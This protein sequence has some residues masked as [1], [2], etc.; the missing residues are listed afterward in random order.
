[1]GKLSSMAGG[2]SC[3]MVRQVTNLSQNVPVELGP[4]GLLPWGQSPGPQNSSCRWACQYTCHPK[5]GHQKTH[6]AIMEELT[7][8]KDSSSSLSGTP[9]TICRLCSPFR[10]LTIFTN[11]CIGY[12]DLCSGTEQ[13]HHHFLG[14][15]SRL[16]PLLDDGR[17]ISAVGCPLGMPLDGTRCCGCDYSCD[18]G[19]SLLGWVLPT[20]VQLPLPN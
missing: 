16:V 19:G 13:L 20:W 10:L 15:S 6:V 9:M 18:Y 12:E 2:W 11:P 14:Q 3:Q 17:S 4:G 1:M 5:W 7:G 8:S